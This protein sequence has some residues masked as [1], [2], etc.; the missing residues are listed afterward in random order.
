[1]H[2]FIH[3]LR[4]VRKT[5]ALSLLV[6]LILAIGIGVNTAV[7]T[8][9]NAALLRPLPYRDPSSLVSVSTLD[10]SDGATNGCLSYPHFRL[11]AGEAH[12]FSGIAAF[13]NET[14][15]VSTGGEVNE[16]PAARVSWNFFDLLGVKPIIG[17]TF[18]AGES[19]AGAKP[20]AIISAE[21]WRRHFNRSPNV[22]GESIALDS[23]P[24]T[25]IGVLPAAF[26]FGLLGSNIEVWVPRY[27]ELNLASAQQIQGGTCYLDGV[28]RLAPG[29]SLA[30]ARAE[31]KILDQRYIRDFSKMGD[32]DPN[33]PLDLQPL[34]T[35]LIGNF[36]SMFL[37]LAV[38]VVLVVLIACA[39]AAGL[40][41]THGLRR[42]RE[43]AIRM[44]LG[45]ARRQLM[46]QFLW[47]V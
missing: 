45:A 14:F 13:T 30:R 11:L 18:A 15:S 3:A 47:R 39:N 29:I 26:Q 31:M 20:V 23:K 19:D 33:R 9:I 10:R 7:F 16:S 22:V 27:D 6:V 46:M 41:L 36:R 35:R 38:A 4:L 12:S 24:Y 34:K 43:V 17:R 28:A 25:I 2:V 21:F 40:L 32:A 1:M 44:A 8:L 5:P 37:M 42:R